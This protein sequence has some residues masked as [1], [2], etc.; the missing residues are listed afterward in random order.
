V[1]NLPNNN[2]PIPSSS[3]S[4]S[5][6]PSSGTSSQVLSDPKLSSQEALGVSLLKRLQQG[7][8]VVAQVKSS[9]VLNDSQKSLLEKVNPSLVEQLGRKLS[10]QN[11]AQ[12]SINTSTNQSGL[13]Q[14]L[15]SALAKTDLHLVKLLV[16]NSNQTLINSQA[17]G[18]QSSL[19]SN[20][21]ANLQSSLLTTVTPHALNLNDKVLL[22]Y[23]NQQLLLKALNQTAIDQKVINQAAFNQKAINQTAI[24]ALPKQEP[25]SLLQ[26]FIHSFNQL[27]DS[28][29]TLFASR[30]TQIQ[31][32]VLSQF[33]LNNIQLGTS[34]QVQQALENSGVTFI[35]KLATNKNLALDLRFAVE[36][37][38]N[39]LNQNSQT[40]NPAQQHTSALFTAKGLSN[41]TNNIKL[42]QQI[43]Q[44]VTT[45]KQE[46]NIKPKELDKL[47]LL[48]TA[49]QNTNNAAQTLALPNKIPNSTAAL[50][51]LLGFQVPGDNQSTL[52]LTQLFDQKLKKL[53][54][55]VQSRLQLSQLRSLNLENALL[56]TRSSPL[57]QF[58]SELSLRFNEQ[59]YPL[60]IHITEKE[61]EQDDTQEEKASDKKEEAQKER[62]WQVFMSFDLPNDEVLHTQVNLVR[63][64]ISATLWTESF[65]LCQKAK[66]EIQ[67]LR[68]KLLAKGLKVEDLICIQ[69]KPPQQDFDFSYNLI[70]ITT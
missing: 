53:I 17:S 7:Q 46:Q 13:N 66:Q 39:S 23:Q 33:I 11:A 61:I 18:L 56:E 35:N 57:Q 62:K 4:T 65:S 67:I 15:N 29:Q 40:G 42:A 48:L 24:Q 5:S 58:H 70:D 63:D 60:Q 54:E 32:K 12:G 43:E 1:I 22:S 26:N 31:L 38:L 25:V 2:G 45:L 44:L 69:G 9:Q 41:T 49:Q 21:Q 28:L 30:D 37:L 10:Q 27:P 6:Q 34:K 20:L 55:Q 59:V 8:T 47:L 36:K 14:N 51:R 52:P 3:P 64:S 68:D 16:Q 19:Q 50:F